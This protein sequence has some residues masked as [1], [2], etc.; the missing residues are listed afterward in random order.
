MWSRA[1][2]WGGFAGLITGLVS[3]ILMF[4]F[5]KYIFTLNEPFLFIAWWS[6]FLSFIMIIL[7]SLL[8]KPEPK[9]KLLGL[10]WKY[11]DKDKELQKALQERAQK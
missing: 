11:A 7:V 8:T 1:T 10:V 9:E 5:K 6:F 2:G 3:A 4:Y